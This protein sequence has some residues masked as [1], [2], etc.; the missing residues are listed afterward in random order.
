MHEN[1]MTYHFV[2]IAC[3]CVIAGIFYCRVSILYHKYYMIIWYTWTWLTYLSLVFTW[4]SAHIR[5]SSVFHW[6]CSPRTEIRH[7][8]SFNSLLIALFCFKSI[9]HTW[10]QCKSRLKIALWELGM[11][12]SLR[13]RLETSLKLSIGLSLLFC[14]HGWEDKRRTLDE[15]GEGESESDKGDL[16]V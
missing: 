2:L 15:V 13:F 14:G 7:K 6:Y 16:L 10:D 5:I 8:S 12:G 3:S 9:G 4:R 1:V 11:M